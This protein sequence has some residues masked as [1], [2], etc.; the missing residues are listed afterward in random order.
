M[1]FNLENQFLLLVALICITCGIFFPLYS[2][3]SAAI[4]A[5]TCLIYLLAP[6]WFLFLVR[7]WMKFG[8]LFSRL[9]S[10][11]ILRVVYFGIFYPLTIL[12]A[13]GR[14]KKFLEHN[15]RWMKADACNFDEEF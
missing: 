11:I 3:H 14:Q 8:L 15:G 5:F 9:L 1:K 2:L 13:L 4:F 6:A 10:P 7:G 12:L